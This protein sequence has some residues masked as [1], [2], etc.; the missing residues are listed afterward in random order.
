MCEAMETG[1]LLAGLKIN[2]NQRAPLAGFITPRVV[3]WDRSGVYSRA[4]PGRVTVASQTPNLRHMKPLKCFMNLANPD[5]D[6]PDP[7]F[8]GAIYLLKPPQQLHR[9]VAT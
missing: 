3:V 8:C 2:F 7:F 5:A 1:L 9:L 6:S 4:A